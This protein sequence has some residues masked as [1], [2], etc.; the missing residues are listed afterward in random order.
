MTSAEFNPRPPLHQATP[1]AISACERRD[2][3]IPGLYI[4]I[5]F[6]FHKCH[7][8][9]FYSIVDRPGTGRDRQ[10]AFTDALIRELR[11][12]AATHD[13]RPRTIFVGGGTPTMLR[14]A[15]W[16]RLLDAMRDA[17]LLE[18]VAEFTVEANPETVTDELIGVLAAGGVNRLSLGAQSFQPRLLE[19]LQRWHEPDS[20]RAAVTQARAAGITNVNLDLIFAIPGQTMEELDADLDALFELAVPHLACYSLIFEPETP[21][22]MKRKLGRVSSSDEETERAMYERV[23]ERLH[24]A[25]YVQYEISNWAKPKATGDC[26]MTID[27]SPDAS[28]SAAT[29]QSAID[30]RQCLHNLLYWTNANWIGVGPSAASHVDG[31]RWKHVPHL[32]RYIDTAPEPPQL[33]DETLDADARRGEQL[34]LGLR[35]RDGVSLEWLNAT[36][37]TDNARWPIIDELIQHKLLERTDTH[38]RLTREG[39]FL[40]DG[41]MSRL[42]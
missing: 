29:R 42:L 19:V 28:T 10:H 20:V 22:A 24:D 40:A 41:V 6:C 1:G 5:P 26:R 25:G 11:H 37:P 35:L 3:P 18:H 8:C 16:R 21:L 17:G 15:L 13:L 7:Y 12:R 4:H 36:L 30:N 14:P 9:D 23:I 34:M 32:G 33:E 38:L 2:R 39:L 31:R 27:D